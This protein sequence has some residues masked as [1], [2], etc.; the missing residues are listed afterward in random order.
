MRRSFEVA[1]WQ[2]S[3]SSAVIRSG[4]FVIR[5]CSSQPYR[6]AFHSRGWHREIDVVELATARFGAHAIERRIARNRFAFAGHGVDR[7]LPLAG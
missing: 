6:T 1:R 4:N 2:R 3:D 7:L 5:D